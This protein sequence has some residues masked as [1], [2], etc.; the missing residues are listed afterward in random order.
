[1]P[2]ADLHLPPPPP[3]AASFFSDALDEV[4]AFVARADGEHSRVVHGSGPLG[5]EWHGLDGRTVAVRW[6]RTA[7]AQTTPEGEDDA[8]AEHK[9]QHG[10]M[11]EDRIGRFQKAVQLSAP[12]SR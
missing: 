3:Q 8:R 11:P 10:V 4:R 12:R 6:G 2:Y 1:M 9:E 7:L 5:Y